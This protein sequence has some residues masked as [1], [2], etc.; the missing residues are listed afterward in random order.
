[1]TALVRYRGC[2]RDHRTRFGAR[3]VVRSCTRLLAEC[4]DDE[5]N[6]L[7]HLR[8]H[9]VSGDVIDVERESFVRPVREDVDERPASKM[10]LKPQVDDLRNSETRQARAQL[11]SRIGNGQPPIDRDRNQF[12][13]APELP[14][15]RLTGG[16][17]NRADALVDIARQVLRMTWSSVTIDVERRSNRENTSVENTAGNERRW[18][19]LT[20]A[21]RQIEA[22]ADQV[23]NAVPGFDAKLHWR[24]LQEEFAQ[25]RRQDD[26][27]EQRI[28]ID[29]Q[30]AA[31]RLARFRNLHCRLG[32]SRK[33][34][35]NPFLKGAS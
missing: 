23:R 3:F 7:P 27:R 24:I 15:E 21:D 26:T 6:E 29:S 9:V 11:G 32:N 20:E 22:V 5:V 31:D 28:D 1:M 25:L 12:F 19:R 13:A 35:G 4:V 18:R 10:M 34:L 33:V 2:E 17:V 14:V 16:S 8:G 30:L